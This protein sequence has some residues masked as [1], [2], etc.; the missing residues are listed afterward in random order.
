MTPGTKK[1]ANQP[2]KKPPLMPTPKSWLTDAR[3]FMASAVFGRL[4]LAFS[5]LTVLG[6]TIY[7][8]LLGARLQLGNA[9]QLVNTQLFKTSAT[10]HGAS[11]PGAHTFLIKWPLFWLAN[12]LGSTNSVIN[13]LTVCL[14][15]LTVG[16]LLAVI[17][18]IERR[19]MVFGTICLALASVLLLVPAAPYAGAILPVN[20]AMLST[21]NIE[22]IMFIISLALL[23]RKPRVKSWGFW[24]SAGVLSLLIAS[25][26]LFFVFAI[27][28]ALIA[29]II[30]ARNRTW[31]VVSMAVN[32]LIASLI[33][34]VAAYIILAVI[35]RSGLTHIASQSTVSPYNL[36]GSLKDFAL[37]GLFGLMGLLTN[38]GANPA[39]AAT[40]VKNI[41]HL[42]QTHLAS[43][44]GP[45]YIINLVILL[46]GLWAV[47]QIIRSTWTVHQFTEKLP[48][49]KAT[50]LSMLLIMSSVVALI[51]FV[52]TNHYYA[53][54]AR[55][56]TIILFTVFIALASYARAR[57]WRPNV[58]AAAGLV[59]VIGI[60]FGLFGTTRNYND[61]KIALASQNDRN[62]Q[63]AQALAQHH[64]DVLVGDY[65][66]VVPIKQ[67]TDSLKLSPAKTK[68]ATKQQTA[69]VK[70]LNVTPLSNCTLPQQAL[71][72][73]T[74]QPNLNKVK[75]A[76]L[77]TLHGN[78]TNY[79]NCTLEQVVSAYGKP[80]ASSLIAGTLS[81]PQELLLYYDRGSQHSSPATV[82]SNSSPSTVL[83]ISPANL[84]YTSC[85]VPS[86]MNIVAHEDDDILFM[87]PDLVNIIKAGDCVRTI[88]I[89]AGNAGVSGDFY[90]LSREEAAEAAYSYMLGSNAVWIQRIV[91]LAPNEYITV[92][93]PKANAKISLI[94][95]HLPDGNL[96][97][98]GFSSSD[99]QSLAKLRSGAIKLINSVDNQS[100]YTSSQLIDALSDLMV[101]Y[102]PSG[103]HTQAG[104]AGTQYPDHSDHLTVN[105]FV[106][107]AYAQFETE[108]YANQVVIPIKYYI[109]YPIHQF[110]TN[111]SGAA[112]QEKAAIFLAYTQYDSHACQTLK[113]CLQ[114]PAYGAYLTRQYQNGY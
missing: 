8:S 30:Y 104:L 26:K 34:A 25:D 57:N 44:S 76:Y 3:A 61:D 77:L 65:W 14:V 47:F 86:Y 64:V 82:E 45:A 107:Q 33:A 111:V 32:W 97:G 85:A 91:E 103:I 2:I 89:T 59:I 112:L 92:A 12:V 18:R 106:K 68:T 46:I 113:S 15:V 39:F 52:A 100:S 96:Q 58:L 16:L 17:Y 90:W 75:F 109:G 41:P 27:G 22:Y 105:W 13:L 54:D 114:D 48:F 101:I 37:G 9:D 102:Q 110:P 62:S 70:A 93:N 56:L 83:P 40:E 98:Q 11:F 53:V 87:N 50:M 94:F 88:Y 84:P 49:S 4:Y 67:V 42:L 31:T 74:W 20:M 5:L 28:G 99:Y 10:F 24:L 72:S 38:F 51:S 108:K 6:T 35:G 1:K 78:L 55:Y 23:I 95:M 81:Q 19:P 29:M 80:N 71:S 66:R 73:S 36:T 43:L 60:I 69:R 21:R 79:P 7:W 63:I